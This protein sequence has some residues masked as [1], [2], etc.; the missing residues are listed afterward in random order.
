MFL[1]NLSIR[2]REQNIVMSMSVCV[3]VSVCLSAGISSRTDRQTYTQTDVLIAILRNRSRG[4]SNK[5]V[6]LFL[7]CPPAQLGIYACVHFPSKIT[8]PI[9]I[10]PSP[11]GVQSIAIS[12]SVC[13]SVSSRNFSKC[14]SLYLTACLSARIS[15][16][17]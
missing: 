5:S 15:Q 4:R 1:F 8:G 7:Y 16:N 2:L 6:T 10:S 9:F 14:L 12:V 3:S 13:L 17:P 11:I